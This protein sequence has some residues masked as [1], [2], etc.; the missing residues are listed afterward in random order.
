M[1]LYNTWKKYYGVIILRRTYSTV[2]ITLY[3]ET[4]YETWMN[5]SNIL[6]MLHQDLSYIGDRC[7][8]DRMLVGFTTTYAISAYH[9]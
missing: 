3:F 6:A 4:V 5:E 1:E 7:G 9:H 2:T 8:G